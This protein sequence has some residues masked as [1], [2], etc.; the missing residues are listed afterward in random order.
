MIAQTGSLEFTQTYHTKLQEQCKL[1]K[2]LQIGL[3]AFASASS[4]D[5]DLGSIWSHTEWTEDLRP[6]DTSNN[7][8]SSMQVGS[9]V[10][11]FVSRRAS[12]SKYGRL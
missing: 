6:K 2:T 3:P 8:K 11:L 7:S 12:A 5:N 9:R 4:A 1:L 10:S